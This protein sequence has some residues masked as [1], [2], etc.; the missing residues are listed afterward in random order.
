MP[1]Y[2]D[3]TRVKNKQIYDETQKLKAEV[4][5]YTRYVRGGYPE[6]R[7]QISELKKKIEINKI[8]AK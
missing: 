7:K 3:D 2:I 5:M 4:T 8:L 6:Y 1:L